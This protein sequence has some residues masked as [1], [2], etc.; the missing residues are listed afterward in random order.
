[1]SIAITTGVARSAI[2]RSPTLRSAVKS[3]R[4]QWLIQ[5]VRGARTVDDP[6]AFAK[7][8]L[9]SKAVR[10]H[11]L[12]GSGLTMTVRHCTRDVDILNEIFS[13]ECYAPPVEVARLLDALESPAI[14]DLGANIGLFGLYAFGRWP[15]ARVLGFE[16]DSANAELLDRTIAANGLADRWRAVRAACSNRDGIAR[17]SAGHLSESKISEAG[18]SNVVEVP[19]VDAFD[20]CRDADILKIDIEGAEWSILTDPRLSQLR[21]FAIVL[22]WHLLESPEPDAAAFA[23]RLLQSAGFAHTR[24]HQSES[25]GN[26]TIWAWR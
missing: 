21:A 7:A 13:V 5:T 10:Q 24:G 14:M 8:Q 4:G 3:R 25:G 22:E 6:W 26:G 18:H 1:M 9:E 12:K 11:Q 15:D 23:T 20:A 16:P 19:M 2:T 17:F